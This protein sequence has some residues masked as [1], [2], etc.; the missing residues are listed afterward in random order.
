M[1]NFKIASL[2]LVLGLVVLG[3]CKDPDPVE[4]S[5]TEKQLALLVNTWK[6][7]SVTFNG[8]SEDSEWTNFT[9]TFS[10]GGYTTTNIS[11]GRENTV[12]SSTGSW[13]FKGAGTDALNVNT[14]VRDD[15]V[16]IAITVSETDLTMSFSYDESIN[17]RSSGIN[18]LDGNWVF[19][20]TK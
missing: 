14:L 17:G 2:V 19:N 8:S 7:P 5:A 12:W 6:N 15:G 13:Q 16:E 10:D 18:G 4:P 9:I 3:S 1:N 11:D 20:M